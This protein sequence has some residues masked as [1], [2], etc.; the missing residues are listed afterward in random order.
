MI[1][2][3]Q[4]ELLKRIEQEHNQ[5][6]L[7]E[8]KKSFKREGNKLLDRTIGCLVES[9]SQPNMSSSSETTNTTAILPTTFRDGNNNSINSA[10]LSSSSSTSAAGQQDDE[11]EVQ[12]VLITGKPARSSLTCQRPDLIAQPP[13]N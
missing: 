12:A 13:I 6:M 1:H 5:L 8:E 4:E 10:N 2:I 3:S 7:L 9:R 11:D